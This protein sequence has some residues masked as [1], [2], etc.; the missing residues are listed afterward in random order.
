[1]SQEKLVTPR[2]V[3]RT[4]IYRDHK[5][6][7]LPY[8]HGD[9]FCRRNGIVLRGV[10]FGQYTSLQQR[11]L[12][13]M[14]CKCPGDFC[15]CGSLILLRDIS[16]SEVE[17]IA[18]SCSKSQKSVSWIDPLT[19][20]RLQ[21][22]THLHHQ[23]QQ[24]DEYKLNETNQT[25]LE[26]LLAAFRSLSPKRRWLLAQS[27]NETT[28]NESAESRV[29]L[30]T[31]NYTVNAIWQYPPTSI[32]EPPLQR[33]HEAQV[34]ESYFGNGWTQNSE[35]VHYEH[36]GGYHFNFW[37]NRSLRG[38]QNHKHIPRERPKRLSKTALAAPAK[39]AEQKELA[40]RQAIPIVSCAQ[41][42]N[43]HQKNLEKARHSNGRPR[44]VKKQIERKWKL[45]NHLLTYDEVLDS[46]EEEANNQQN[47]SIRLTNLTI[48][49]FL[50]LR[51]ETPDSL[52]L[53]DYS[54]VEIESN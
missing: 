39:E 46:E 23:M 1:M 50:D 9:N 52:S 16:A 31:S 36:R 37:Y 4:Q 27:L 20:R 45:P 25:G 28:E 34:Q 41:E 42:S 14:P 18:P 49:D 24:P 40:I 47:E 51:T 2:A 38:P 53:S 7:V 22:L 32:V 8:K 33:V 11:S 21:H 10:C 13:E 35:I 43:G 29:F 6:V 44:H 17:Q 48:G 26:T 30:I 19:L 3:N 54:V 5:K 12:V 15:R